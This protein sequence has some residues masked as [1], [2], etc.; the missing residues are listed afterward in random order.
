MGCFIP[1]CLFWLLLGQAKSN[2]H[3]RQGLKDYKDYGE[4]VYCRL[5]ACYQLP[6]TRLIKAAWFELK[7]HICSKKSGIAKI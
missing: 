3:I 7:F 2:K 6:V 5:V 4:K 1:G